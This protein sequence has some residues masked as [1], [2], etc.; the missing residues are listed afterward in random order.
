VTINEILEHFPQKISNDLVDYATDTVFLKSRYLFTRRV[1]G[2]QK[3][4]CTHCKYE[5]ITDGLKHG[6]KSECAK[7]RSECIV[8]ASGK[9]R[10]RLIDDAFVVWY[11]KSS[12]NPK[13]IV[14]RGILLSRDY[15]G[16]Y[17]TVETQFYTKVYY[18]F[19]P[20]NSRMVFRDWG[21]LIERKKISSE[22]YAS[23]NF[24][25]SFVCTDNIKAAVTDTPFQY[26]TWERY[27]RYSD[28][29]RIK[30]DMVRF[31][32]LAA[33]YPCIEYLTKLGMQD[34]VQTK[35]DGRKTFGAINW[36]GKTIEK[37]LRL[38]KA[39]IKDLRMNNINL[40]VDTL[41][42]YQVHKKNGYK[43]TFEEAELL[44]DITGWRF[45]DFKKLLQYASFEKLSRYILKQLRNHKKH[46]SA[47]YSVLISLQDYIKDCIDLG[48]DITQE[49]VLL[50]NNLHAAHQKTIRQV[51]FKAD[52]SLNKKIE[53]R[54]RELQRFSF[55]YS[56]MIIRP[57]V[58]SIE[59]FD[60]GKALHH[61]VGRYAEDYANGK[62]NIFVIR[63]AEEP[64]KPFYTMEIRHNQIT[65]VYGKNNKQPTIEVK[66]FV[67]AF[68]SNKLEKRL[69]E[70]KV[71]V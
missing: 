40:K 54:I 4:Y 20:G 68:K 35:L 14:A 49:H 18:L 34:I 10:K 5:T 71:A 48:M 29:Y 66:E 9:G 22:V 44:N 65:Q 50:P 58:S 41:H 31:F 25:E 67:E 46:F 7:C 16:D 47:S 30:D 52:A 62:T 42:C 43:I 24:K 64:D 17:R 45:D 59:L 21:G 26:S 61:C 11:E 3:A 32:D 19:E 37:V 33:K 2:F 15:S 38:S 60:E 39:E 6:Q 36:R 27:H 57:A 69:K 23:M 1:G 12:M 63:K 28:Q 56:G 8:K 55:R 70:R 13:A 51:K 53:K